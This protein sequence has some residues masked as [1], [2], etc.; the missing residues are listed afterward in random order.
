VLLASGSPRRRHFLASVRLPFEVVIP[1]VDE[2]PLP[3]E[4]PAQMVQRLAELKARD[5]HRRNPR[6]H[7]LVLAADTDVVLDGRT[8]GKPEDAADAAAMLR[9]LSGREHQVLTGTCVLDQSSGRARTW[10][11][12]TRVWFRDL[13]DAEIDGYIATGEPLDKA[14]SY[15][16]QGIGAFLIARVEGSYTNVVGLPLGQVL[17]ELTRQGGPRAFGARSEPR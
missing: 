5:V 14:G 15:A 10:L 3:G 2:T 9:A 11:A 4:G 17:D 1:E 6:Q 7:G 16:C 12:E 13:D 8:L